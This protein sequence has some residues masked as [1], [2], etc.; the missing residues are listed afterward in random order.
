M[1][2][3][4][5]FRQQSC[6]DEASEMGYPQGVHEWLTEI[7]GCENDEAAVQEVGPVT[8]YEG[9]LL[10]FPNILQH[11]VQPFSLKYPDKPG[12]RKILALF[13]VDPGIR[14]ISTANVPPQQKD[15]WSQEVD[16]QIA[17]TGKALGKLSNEIKDK[18][19]EQVEDFPISMETAKELRLK[20]ME[21]RS[22]Y[23]TNQVSS[24]EK[25]T[26]SLCEH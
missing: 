18:V 19:F 2:S 11:K 24:F 4:L 9:R 20:L 25:H 14:I 15:W 8:C 17:G 13:L 10:T 5:S 16:R 6:T 12:H 22:I 3:D 26:F 1:P 23:V 7:Y 21:E